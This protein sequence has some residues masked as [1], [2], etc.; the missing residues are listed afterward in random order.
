MPSCSEFLWETSSSISAPLSEV[1]QGRLRR[2]QNV[3]VSTKE[4]AVIFLFTWLLFQAM[5]RILAAKCH[6]SD[7]AGPSWAAYTRLWICRTI[8]SGRSAQVFVDVNEKYGSVARIGPNHLVT[9]DPELSR[10]ILAVGSKWCRAPWFDAIRIDPRVPNIVSERD[11]RRH[12]QMRHRMSA[13]YAGKDIQ[14]LEAAVDERINEFIES[15]E[16]RWISQPGMTIPLD[17]ARR[18]QFLTIDT[19]THLCFGKPM[20]FV[21]SDTDKFDFI[22]T[23]QTQLPIA[24]HFTVILVLNNVLRFVAALPLLRRLVVP[25][26]RDKSGIGKIMK[27][28]REVIIDRL[29][30][31]DNQKPDML[32]SFMKRGLTPEQAEM[33]ISITLVAGSD[34][35][36]TAMRATLLAIISTPTV[37]HR[38][39]Q[40]IDAAHEKGLLSSPVKNSEALQMPFLQAVIREGLRRF[41]PITQLRE[42]ES[43][44]GG[45]KLAD[46]RSIPGGVFVGF[47]AWG[48]Q[49][50]PVFGDDPQVFRPERWLPENYSDG[51]QRLAEMGK[52]YEL[53][54]GYGLTRCLGIPI[55]MMNLNKVFV[56][57]FRR[58]D[59]QC[60]N[61]QRPWDSQCFGIFF[62]K[63]FN[64][65]I[66]RREE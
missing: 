55:A 37:Y 60:I 19:I 15:I 28:S 65:R 16:Q 21:N 62:Q 47:N 11:Q 25:S 32:G 61:N 35:T 5:R 46:G 52:V 18:L 12:N 13:G 54:F 58:Y 38:L 9:S 48:L 22:A 3:R 20:G 44:P 64:V 30:T 24:Q 1:W 7:F 40:E 59:I 66:I 10:Q 51:G 36:A 53:I 42:R 56:E 17:I 4:A 23:I 8:A 33:E 39:Q 49:L 34:T 31:P 6:L 50:H 2:L 57:L 43:P 14:G 27:L 26:S 45:I 41:P 29:D 63:N